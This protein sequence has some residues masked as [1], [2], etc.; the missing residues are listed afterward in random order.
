[1]IF[2]TLREGIKQRQARH[3]PITLPWATKVVRARIEELKSCGYEL[4]VKCKVLR[5]G[6]T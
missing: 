2:P 4:K 3:R 5:G 1:M 6:T